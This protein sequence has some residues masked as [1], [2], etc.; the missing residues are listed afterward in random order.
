MNEEEILAKIDELAELEC[1]WD[2]YGAIPLTKE[3]L[4]AARE[5]V[6]VVSPLP[7]HVAP[8]GKGGVQLEWYFNS[9]EME[10]EF[11]PNGKCAVL[12]TPK[13]NGV[14]R[15]EDCIEWSQEAR[16]DKEE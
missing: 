5:A 6:K 9:V 14:C 12:V 7:H 16:R 2:S 15:W 10:L 4:S 1:N 13:T 11:Y 3:A 8:T